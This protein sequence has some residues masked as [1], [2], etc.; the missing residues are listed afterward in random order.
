MC[1]VVPA[2]ACL[3]TRRHLKKSRTDWQCR[4]LKNSDHLAVVEAWAVSRER[5]LSRADQELDVFQV[6]CHLGSLASASSIGWRNT[7]FLYALRK[8]RFRCT[9]D[10]LPP[11]LCG[12][13]KMNEAI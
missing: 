6:D 9:V 2:F 3:K 12:A 5:L 10:G 4:K 8:L 13:D 1:T 7:A 11:W